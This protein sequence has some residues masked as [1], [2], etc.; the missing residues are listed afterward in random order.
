LNDQTDPLFTNN[1]EEKFRSMRDCILQWER[2]N[3][4]MRE[5]EPRGALHAG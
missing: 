2:D 5:R 3:N 1:I 4:V